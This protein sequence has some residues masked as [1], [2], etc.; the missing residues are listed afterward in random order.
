MGQVQHRPVRE[1]FKSSYSTPSSVAT[2][3][4]PVIELQVAQVHVRQPPPGPPHS[5]IRHDDCRRR[6]FHLGTSGGQIRHLALVSTLCTLPPTN[7]FNN[8]LYSYYNYSGR[9]RCVQE[10]SWWID[11]KASKTQ[12]LSWICLSTTLTLLCFPAHSHFLREILWT[13]V[14][15]LWQT[16][17]SSGIPLP[18]PGFL[19]VSP[20]IFQRRK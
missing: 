19:F 20:M 6:W 12:R 10:K 13:E 4:F 14:G 17:E 7:Q 9:W 5:H 8:K 16:W 18:C 15:F 1:H 3:T 11:W 2:L